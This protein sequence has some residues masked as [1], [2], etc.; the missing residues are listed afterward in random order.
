MSNK[1][2]YAVFPI[3]LTTAGTRTLHRFSGILRMIEATDA[4]GADDLTAKVEVR[5]GDNEGD[6]IPLKLGNAVKA[7][8]VEELTIRWDAQVGTTV[9]FFSSR[10]ANVADVDADPPSQ[11]V[12]GDK[13][14]LATY[15]TV[16][17]GTSAGVIKAANGDRKQI[18]IENVHASNDLYIG[19]D[20]SVT[21]ANGIKIPAGGTFTT[22]A[23]TGAFYGIASGAATDV[24]YFEEG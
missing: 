21:T 7:D 11:L 12:L 22:D 16:S 13:A 19:G 18:T 1:P 9:K 5:L 23:Y 3:L 4:T 6:W 14:S 10:D 17:I 15:A 20:A 8:D 24:R 2:N